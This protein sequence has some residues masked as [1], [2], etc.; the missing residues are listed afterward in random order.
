MMRRAIGKFLL[1]KKPGAGNDLLNHRA[2]EKNNVNSQVFM[3]CSGRDFVNDRIAI[4][5]NY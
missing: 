5:A 4:L 3:I 2:P 1:F